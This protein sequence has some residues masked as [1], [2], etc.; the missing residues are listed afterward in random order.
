MIEDE[1]GLESSLSEL[2]G[3]QCVLT[4]RESADFVREDGEVL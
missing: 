2:G 4:M 1:S 3:G